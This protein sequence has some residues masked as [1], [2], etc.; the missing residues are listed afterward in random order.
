VLLRIVAVGSVGI[1]LLSLF[2]GDSALGY[3]FLGLSGLVATPLLWYYGELERLAP[4][5]GSSIDASLDKAILARMH[6]DITPAQLVSIVSKQP[7]GYFFASRFAIGTEFL[8]LFAQQT[9]TE[10]IFAKARQL[11]TELGLATIDSSMLVA[12]I[13]LSIPSADM[14]LGHLELDTQDI[15]TAVKWFNHIQETIAVHTERKNF[16]GIGRD[17][18]F[19]WAPM[20]NRVGYNITR[21]IESG[22]FVHRSLPAHDDVIAQSLHVLAQPGRRNVAL[23]GEVGVGKT[24]IVHSLANQLIEAKS[25]TPPNLQYNQVIS[26]DAAHLI[27]IAKGRGELEGLIAHLFNEAISA[28]NIIL[29][30]DEAQLFLQD[31]TGSVD[32]S[33]ILIPVLEGG[34]LKLV[35]SLDEQ[36]WLR[37]S[38]TN[39]GLAQ[40][41]NRVIVKPLEEDDTMQVLEDGVLLMEGKHKVVYMRQAL[42]EAYKLANRFIHEQAMPGKAIRLLEAAA[43]FAEEKHFITARSVQQ[44]VEK[45]F[46]VRV[47]N[48]N[49]AEERDVLLNL[50]DKIHERMINQSRAVKLVSDALRRARAGVRNESK[51]IGTF[52]FLGPTGVGKTELS[53]ALAAVYFGGEERMVRVDLNEFSHA[54]DTNRLLAVGATDP[55]SLCAQIA[56]Q[57]FSVVLLD[58][59]EK[60]HPNVLNLLLQMLDE[61]TLRDAQNKSISFRDAV[62]IATSNAGADKIREHIAA[63]QQLEQFEKQ[64]VDELIDAQLFRPEFLNRFDEI[65]LFRPLSPEELTQ[66]VDLLIAGLNK[67][68]AAQKVTVVLTQEAK[69]LLANTGYDPRLGA[70]PLRR[71]VQRVVENL[72]AQRMLQGD[73]TSGQQIQLDAPDIQ[74]ALDT[75][76]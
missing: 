11:Q 23:V 12:A 2:V 19:G 67:R 59:I 8:D 9:T 16:G 10:Q 46:D 41:M 3:V 35:L 27:S 56:K 54:D 70:R 75:S 73:I 6:A 64:F 28:K 72:V 50:E 4:A 22:A 57:P 55:Y 43:G 62:I 71:V 17:L 61:G 39:A 53:K 44:A 33:N 47:Q 25:V 37:I 49:T 13:C 52:L 30:L 20:L 66:V 26:L 51:P 14:M 18:S 5:A 38:Q 58:E 7:G 32:L 31:G 68:L 74:S 76:A 45:S 69:V 63:G 36:H 1:W 48:A 21:G 15:M 24:T 29:F 65:I 42:Q 34:A 40:L 60:A